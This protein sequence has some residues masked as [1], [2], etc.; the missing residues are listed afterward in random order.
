MLLVI[1]RWGRLMFVL[2]IFLGEFL[3]GQKIS[4]DEGMGE[5]KPYESPAE[6]LY[7]TQWEESLVRGDED[8]EE[9]H[10]CMLMESLGAKSV[11]EEYVLYVCVLQPVL[12]GLL[13]IFAHFVSASFESTLYFK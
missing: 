2:S 8:E 9:K 13:H 11:F 1:T 6:V 7:Q 4:V 12:L 3:F 10:F 5:K